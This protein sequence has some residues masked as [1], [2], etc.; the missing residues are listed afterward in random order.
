MRL[1]LVSYT[2]SCALVIRRSANC[3]LIFHGDI[4]KIK[5]R[6]QYE[7]DDRGTMFRFLTRET[8]SMKS[9]DFLEWL[10]IDVACS[11]VTYQAVRRQ[12]LSSCLLSCGVN[13]KAYGTQYF[14]MYFAFL[15]PC[16]LS[17]CIHPSFTYS[18]SGR[19][20]L[21][22]SHTFFPSLYFMPTATFNA[23]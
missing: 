6:S 12:I 14:N 13:M 21:I 18:E 20:L 3:N 5:W 11:V 1:N 9:E 17:F 2:A 16:S 7:L 4:A 8:D 23:L 10:K 19:G 15:F 22:R